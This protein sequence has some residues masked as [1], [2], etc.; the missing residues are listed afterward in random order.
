M[1]PAGEDLHEHRD[2][3]ALQGV[4]H[5]LDKMRMVVGLCLVLPWRLERGILSN[6]TITSRERS[7]ASSAQ[8]QGR[9]RAQERSAREGLIWRLTR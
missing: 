4:E 6:S 2:V 1:D 8:P 7:L 9:R 5:G 3:K